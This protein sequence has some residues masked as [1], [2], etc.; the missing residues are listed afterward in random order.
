MLRTI[1]SNNSRGFLR[2]RRI[3]YQQLSSVKT[4]PPKRI[5][6]DLNRFFSIS[7]QSSQSSQSSTSIPTHFDPSGAY[8]SSG[9]IPTA[10]YDPSPLPGTAPY[11]KSHLIISPSN[12]TRPEWT[13]PSHLESV[14]PFLSELSSR[15]NTGG[16]LEG[17]GIAFS[18]GFEDVS[19][20]VGD[21]A[22][23]NGNQQVDRFRKWDSKTSKFM[24]PIP[25]DLSE[26]ESFRIDVFNSEG[27]HGVVPSISLKTLD[28]DQPFSTKLLD[29]ISN[30]NSNTKNDEV[31]IYVCI[32]GTRDCRCGLVGPQVLESLKEEVSK[33]QESMLSKGEVSKKKVRL[34]GISHVGGHKWAVNALVY[35]HGDWYGN[36]RTSDAP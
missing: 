27:K 14:S 8:D 24:R 5:N 33:H 26:D 2:N 30:S 3:K 28:L 10:P 15:T 7:S 23:G 22:E 13:W 20:K 19:G 25:N 16:S 1:L 9:R 36:L 6:S 4:L 12:S 21:G 11:Y 17:Y 34:A 35:P 29:S 31:H 32:H 18:Q